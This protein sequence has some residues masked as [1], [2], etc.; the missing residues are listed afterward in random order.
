MDVCSLQRCPDVLA[1][2]LSAP[3]RAAGNN[4]SCGY[5]WDWSRFRCH[6]LS[7]TDGRA[8]FSAPKVGLGRRPQHSNTRSPACC[9]PG[10][11][12][13]TSF[14]A[15]GKAL[16]FLPY[17][18][19]GI[20]RLTCVFSRLEKQSRTAGWMRVQQE[21][22]WDCGLGDGNEL[23]GKDFSPLAEMG[24]GSLRACCAWGC[25]AI[26]VHLEGSEY[27]GLLG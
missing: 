14:S 23:C 19:Q 8:S 18:I 22:P 17:A 10:I 4:A 9:Q 6:V 26:Q 2:G 11:E 25:K 15:P 20:Y 21:H 1:K 27:T 7:M 16:P 3:A 12:E 24:L 5:Q 13:F